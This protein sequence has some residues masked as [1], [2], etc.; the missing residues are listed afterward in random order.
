VEDEILEL[1]KPSLLYADDCAAFVS[2]FRGSLQP[3]GLELSETSNGGV[4]AQQLQRRHFDW[5]AQNEDQTYNAYQKS[6][7]WVAFDAATFAAWSVQIQPGGIILDVGCADGRSCFPFV[8]RGNTII[9]FDISKALVRQAIT[10]AITANA[11]ASTTFFVSDA[12]VLPFRDNTV[13]YIVIYGVLHH[14]PNPRATCREVYRIL[15][16]GGVY[17]GSEN[18]VSMFRGIFDLLMKLK[19]IWKEEAGDQPLISCE[20]IQQWLQDLPILFSCRSSVFL[21]PQL[22]NLLGHRNAAGALALSDKL[23]TA[24]PGLREQGGLI[25]FEVRKQLPR[26]AAT[27]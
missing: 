21:P 26:G 24:V 27:V 2:R 25:V 18:N 12:S 14:V 20:H 10:R 19:P 16:P 7:F 15:K 23:C 3:L 9:G 17:L 6:P 5:Y 22:L 11:Q 8:N 4:S 1:V 13:D